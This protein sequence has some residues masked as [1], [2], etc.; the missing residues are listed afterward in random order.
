MGHGKDPARAERERGDDAAQLRELR[1][2]LEGAQV[3][4]W[5]WDLRTNKVRE[6]KD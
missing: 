4:L 5:T 1:T 2:A 6:I 3:G